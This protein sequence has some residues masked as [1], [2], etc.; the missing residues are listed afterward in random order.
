MFPCA[1]KSFFNIDCPICG[2]QR[3]LIFL[4]QG[5]FKKSFL[6]YPPL[7]P[8]CI[9]IVLFLIHLLN[10]QLVPR[11]KLNY[12][13]VKEV[14]F[15]FARFTNTDTIL[16]PEMKSTGEAIRFI[17]DLRDPYFRTLY[18]ERSMNLSR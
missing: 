7:V 13:S 8:A 1:S 14:V 15:P 12:F 2:F 11:K 9:L 18:K 6:M 4:L 17:K 10:K 16:G 3:S 5:D